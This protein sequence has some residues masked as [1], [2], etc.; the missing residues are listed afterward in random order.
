VHFSLAA[1][2][3]S[4]AYEVRELESFVS[5]IIVLPLGG[6][7]PFFVPSGGQ[8]ITLGRAE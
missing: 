8:I 2:H 3:A 7:P 5:V 4:Q 6:F 1:L